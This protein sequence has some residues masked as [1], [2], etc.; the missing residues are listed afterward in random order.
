MKQHHTILTAGALALLLTQTS[1]MSQ[2]QHE[3]AIAQVKVYQTRVHD[4]EAV[5]HELEMRIQE[6]KE[7]LALGN[8][9]TTEAGFDD[10]IMSRLNEYEELL[11]SIGDRPI[12]GVE[13]FVLDGGVLFMVQDAV[14][15]NL[16]STDISP[17]GRNALMNVASQIREQD[18][19]RVWVRGHTDSTPI[20]KAETKKRFPH[21]NLQLSSERALEVASL[22]TASGNLDKS[23]VAVVGFGPHEPIKPN[24]STDNKRLNRRV[25]IFV[26]DSE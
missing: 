3:E 22:L 18:Y 4:L 6:L 26:V 14:L 15:F 2:A 13:R 24:D 21:G 11:R 5:N 25:E 1:C 20:V 7:Q 16:G 19:G 12:Q 8:I 23:R 9:G 17:E 10:D